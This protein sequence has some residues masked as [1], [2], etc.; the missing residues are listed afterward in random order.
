M[1]FEDST[2]FDFSKIGRTS[3]GSSGTSGA[4]STFSSVKDLL[5]PITSR[6]N[7]LVGKGLFSG[8]ASSIPKAVPQIG[9]TGGAGGGVATTLADDD[10]RV[11]ISLGEEAYFFYKSTM[12]KNNIQDPLLETGGVIWPYTPAINITHMASYNAASLTHSNYPAQFYNNSEISDIS[13]SGEFTVQSMEEG[14]YLLAVIYFLRACTKMFFGQGQYA[15]NPPPMVFLNGYGSHYFPNVPC[16][17]TSFQHTMPADVDYI[18]VPVDRVNLVTPT[19]APNS[20]FTNTAGPTITNA[21]SSVNSQP[22]GVPGVVGSGQIVGTTTSFASGSGS[23]QKIISTS[24]RLPTSSTVAVTLKPVYSRVN[25][26]NNF[27]LEKFASGELVRTRP[28]G[29]GGFI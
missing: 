23:S 3:T 10:W 11:R 18:Q 5:N 17:I 8:G 24:T 16:V 14:R 29:T 28:A 22:V 7:N 15:G 26:H 9:F 12:G 21:F 27:D 4:G 6:L 1:A 13:I 19:V 25:L 2:G 20:T